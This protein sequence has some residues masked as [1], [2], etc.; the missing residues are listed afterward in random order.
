[1]FRIIFV[2]DVKETQVKSESSLTENG[3]DTILKADGK[4]VKSEEERMICDFLFYNGVSY[5]YERVYEFD[6]V[7]EKYF[8]I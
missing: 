1:M 3:K 4:Q 5:E 2:R 6:T 7:A 8:V